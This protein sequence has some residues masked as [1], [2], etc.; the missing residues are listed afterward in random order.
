MTATTN[1]NSNTSNSNTSNSNTKRRLSSWALAFSCALLPAAALAEALAIHAGRLFDSER[2]R[3]LEQQTVRVVN[4]RIE[5]VERGY[6]QQ[7]GDRVVDLRGYTILPGLMDMHTHLA[8]EYGPRSYMET[9]TWNPADYTLRGVNTAERT[10]MA[11][12]TTVRDLGDRANVTVSLRNAIE[13]GTVRGPRIFTAAKSIATTGGHADP[14]NGYR[15]DLM[16]SPGPEEGVVNGADSARQAVRQR[17]KDGADLIK[18]TATGGV[19]S[20]AKSGQNP[21]F[22]Q[23]EL[24]AIVAAA[25]DYGCTVAVHAHGKEGMERAIRAG[26]DS[27]EHGTLMDDETM[28]LMKRHKTWYVPT[29]MAG[30][31]VA[32]KAAIE[33]FFPDLVRPKAAELGPQLQRT[34]ASA[35]K[36]G[37]P[38]AFGTD[39]GVSRHG[40][41]AQEFALMVAA[42]MP[43]ADAIRS[44][45]WNAAQLLKAEDELGSISAGKHADIIAVAGN[46]LQDI[47]ELQRV[48]FVMKG[49]EVVK[50]PD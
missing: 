21:Q 24:E 49:G 38:I 10:L 8:F 27:I 1:S 6:V 9:F 42:G 11:G 48:R 43:P 47:S 37:V 36:K 35:Y 18:I 45:T 23:D 46:P 33:G 32:Q 39:T 7:P 2:G 41:N 14:S 4:G 16:G 22:M 19:L 50:Q 30:Q 26:V 44:A 17:Y 13:R 34:F 15:A 5:S 31:W 28:E 29:L 12:F 20:V 40:D 3:L 25:R